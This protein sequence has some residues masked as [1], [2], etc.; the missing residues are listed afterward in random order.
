MVPLDRDQVKPEGMPVSITNLLLKS[1]DQGWV[2]YSYSFEINGTRTEESARRFFYVG[3][4]PQKVALLPVAQVRGA[5]DLHI[6]ADTISDNFLTV[7]VL[8]YENMTAGDVVTFL[9][10]GYTATGTARPVIKSVI[11]L[12]KEQVGQPLEFTVQKGQVTIIKNGK[13]EISYSIAYADDT[14]P[15]TQGGL[16]EQVQHLM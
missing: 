2:F 14:R 7:V 15:V 13:A 9:W 8:P 6:D 4:R 12:V 5:H 3:K 16:K 11:E 1:L 10:Q